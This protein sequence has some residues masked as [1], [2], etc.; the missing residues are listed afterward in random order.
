[1]LSNPTLGRLMSSTALTSS[2]PITANSNRWREVDSTLAPRSRTCVWPFSVGRAEM[3]AG[4][5]IPGRVFSTNR[6]IAISAPVLPALTHASAV[7]SRTRSSTTRMDESRFDRRTWEGESSISTLCEAC[8]TEMRPCGIAPLRF[9]RINDDRFAADQ[10]Q[11]D[12]GKLPRRSRA[13]RAP[14]LPDR[15]LRP[16]HRGR[17]CSA[18]PP[19][20]AVS[21]PGRRQPSSPGS[22][23]RGSPDAGGGF[24]RSSVRSTSSEHAMRHGPGAFHAWTVTSCFAGPPFRFSSC[25]VAGSPV[26]K[27]GCGDRVYRSVQSL[28]ADVANAIHE[29]PR[30]GWCSVTETARRWSEPTVRLTGPER[31]DRRSLAAR[32]AAH[33]R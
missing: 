20:G 9:E 26:R 24:L 12:I 5:S 10:N 17:W 19:G 32:A 2:E 25:S 23:H 4:R 1:M 8:R 22:T 28:R 18:A 6:A 21:R 33:P 30:T 11:I 3:M 15:G 7:P 16:S 14:R 31:V 13:R 27:S 29:A